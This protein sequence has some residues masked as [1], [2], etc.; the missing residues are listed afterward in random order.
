MHTARR[1]PRGG[2][3]GGTARACFVRPND[4]W[5][6]L[7][8]AAWCGCSR[9]ASAGGSPRRAIRP[10]AATRGATRGSSNT[11]GRRCSGSRRARPATATQRWREDVDLVA[12]LGL[13]AYRFSVEWARVEPAEGA[14]LG[15]GSRALPRDRRPLPRAGDRPGGD[16]Q[17]LHLAALVRAARRVARPAGPGGVR[18]LLR[19]RHRAPRR[20]HR[21]GRDAQRAEPPPAAEL[22]GHPRRGARARAGDAAGRERAGRRASLPGRQ[23][24]AAG[25][26]GRHGR[27]HGGRPPGGEGRHQGPASRPAGGAQPRDRRRPGGGGRRVG[28]GP[29]ARRGVRPVAGAGARRRL[30]G[31]AELRAR[32]VRRRRPRAPCRREPCGTRWAGT[33]TRCRWRERSATRTRRPASPCS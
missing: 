26:D 30:R 15:G 10:R 19:R 20:R 2:W 11:C 9:R 7:T 27:R 33:S 16:V 22:A 5:A 12:G 6:V 29:Q 21:L 24:R 18:P 31:R 8:F 3:C 1:G 23:R 13:D 32:P 14:V 28:P 17:P 25:G 4:L